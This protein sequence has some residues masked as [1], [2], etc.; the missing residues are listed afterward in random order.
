MHDDYKE[1]DFDRYC[2]TCK[3]KDVADIEDPC[4]GCLE[5]PVNLHSCKPVNYEEKPTK[6]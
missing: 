5:N 3:Y 6:K 4:D 1:V 2:E